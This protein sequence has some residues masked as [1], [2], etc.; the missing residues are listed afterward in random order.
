MIISAD[1]EK[2]FHKIQHLFLIKILIKLRIEEIFSI[3]KRASMK[4]LPLS[5]IMED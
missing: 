1:A 4:Q 2:E 3:W 5:L